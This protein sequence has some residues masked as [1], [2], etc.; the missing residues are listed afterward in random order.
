MSASRFELAWKKRPKCKVNGVWLRYIR[1][2][3]GGGKKRKVYEEEALL[4]LF[5]SLRN[6]LSSYYLSLFFYARHCVPVICSYRDINRP[7][8]VVA[9]SL[10]VP[11][12][13]NTRNC[14]DLE[15]TKSGILLVHEV[16][17]ILKACMSGKCTF[18]CKPD[19][20]TEATNLVSMYTR[21]KN[22]HSYACLVSDSRSFFRSGITILRG[23]CWNPCV[24]L[25]V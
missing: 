2:E 17:R 14:D 23:D 1:V 20:N 9:V 8:R 24:F 25:C 15:A 19:G 21:D 18:D 12:K 5:L 10:T 3:N 22:E 11:S 7:R 16:A 4:K 13:R 6:A